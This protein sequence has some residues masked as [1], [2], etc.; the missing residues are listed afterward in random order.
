VKSL[1]YMEGQHNEPSAERLL[2]RSVVDCL[3]TETHVTR[4]PSARANRKFLSAALCGSHSPTA[5]PS[6]SHVT[7]FH[8]NKAI[9]RVQ[10]NSLFAKRPGVEACL[11]RIVL[12]KLSGNSKTQ[13][14]FAYLNS[15]HSSG[16]AKQD[17]FR[18]GI[19]SRHDNV[20]SYLGVY[21]WTVT[22][23]DKKAP[24]SDISAIAHT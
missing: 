5:S 6:Q 10:Q 9:P 15:D 19:K 14:I 21:Q 7:S 23:N 1:G 22:G 11:E 3:I 13:Q 4:V 8:N 16:M 20:D 17:F 18:F 24:E 12:F 2:F